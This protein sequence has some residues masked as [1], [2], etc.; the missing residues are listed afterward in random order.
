MAKYTTSNVPYNSP[1]TIRTISGT[2]NGYGTSKTNK[3]NAELEKNIDSLVYALGTMMGTVLQHK[4]DI[5]DEAFD[6]L[7]I[8]LTTISN[9]VILKL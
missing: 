7:I 6:V 9:D 3:T 5:E 4:L 8:E 1:N 2:T